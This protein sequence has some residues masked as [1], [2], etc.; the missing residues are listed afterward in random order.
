MALAAQE[1]PAKTINHSHYWVQAVPE[2]PYFGDHSGGEAHRGDIEPELDDEGDDVAE[3][4]VLDIER[5]E[6]EGGAEARQDCEGDEEGKEEDLHARE[7][8][9][10]D[11]DAGE[12]G[13][14]YSEVD[15]R[16][17]SR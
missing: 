5:R 12:Y 15:E 16:D 2:A 11:H 14:V 3:I 1:A 7:H 10:P 9:V 13:K 8:F 17:G 4:A 6:E